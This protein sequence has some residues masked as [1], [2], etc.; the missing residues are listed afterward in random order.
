MENNGE[1]KTY[2]K[3]DNWIYDLRLNTI[4]L[5]GSTVD[6]IGI[7]DVERE[8]YGNPIDLLW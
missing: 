1:K 6:S 4:L 2:E 8:D 3:P 5:V 7:P